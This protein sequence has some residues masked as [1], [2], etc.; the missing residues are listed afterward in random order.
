MPP[1]KSTRQNSVVNSHVETESHGHSHTMGE[2]RAPG[3]GHIPGGENPFGGG[4]VLG[5]ED[6]PVGGPQ[7]MALMFEMIKGMQQAQV[8]LVD[9]YPEKY[10]TPTFAFFDGRKESVMEHISKFLD[11]MGPFAA[12]ALS[13]QLIGEDLVKYIHRFR[14]VSLD[15]HVKY[16]E[17]ELVEVCIDNMLPEFRTFLENLD[18][19]RFAPLLQ[20]ARKTAV[21]QL[22]PMLRRVKNKKGPTQAL[23]VSTA[24][25][26]SGTKQKNRMKE[27]THYNSGEVP[28]ATCFT[29][30]STC[31][32]CLLGN[33]PNAITF[34]QMKDMEV[35][36]PITI[37]AHFI[38]LPV[39]KDVAN[40]RELL[41]QKKKRKEREVE[42]GQKSTAM[43]ARPTYLDGCALFIAYEGCVGPDC[44]HCK[45][46]PIPEEG[47]L[48]PLCH[49][50]QQTGNS[51]EDMVNQA[52]STAVKTKKSTTAEPKMICQRRTRDYLEVSWQDAC[53]PPR[54]SKGKAA[55]EVHEKVLWRFSDEVSLLPQTSNGLDYFWPNMSAEEA[56][57]YKNMAT[58]WPFHTW[59]LDLIGP[60][61][62]PS[63][64]YIWI[65]V[66]TEYFSKWVEAVP[67]CKATGAAMANFIHEHIITRS[68]TTDPR[69]IT[70]KAMDKRRQLISMLLRILS[71]MVFDYGKGWKALTWQTHYGH[72][73]AQPR[74]SKGSRLRKFGRSKRTWPKFKVVYETTIRSLPCAYRKTLANQNFCQGP[75]GPKNGGPCEKSG[76]YKLAKVD[77]TALWQTPSMGNG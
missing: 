3:G 49:L 22:N 20:K 44:P 53:K 12:H 38:C 9:P 39:V 15:C 57:V 74:R 13:K 58:P 60:I 69:L 65:L 29:V 68:S 33:Q 10:D 71:K 8:E 41:E 52:E 26:A 19:S 23:I 35:Q 4:H 47:G 24:A 45:R 55:I 6:V 14:D 61:N 5:G 11:F 64:G 18:I 31:Q 25:T 40:L 1:K 2:T 30:E 21:F 43:C 76:Y 48:Q 34:H 56:I 59:G 42:C 70:P 54:G 73:V 17:G 50:T 62:P 51:E 77:G 27:G 36:Y 67:L 37:D 66:A 28:G 16:Q 72:I 63:G 46:V 7:Q 32:P 75:D